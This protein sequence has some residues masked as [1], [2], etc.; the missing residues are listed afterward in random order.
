MKYILLFFLFPFSI[1][2]KER[3]VVLDFVHSSNVSREIAISSHNYFISQ[4]AKTDQYSI[5]EKSQLREILKEIEFQ[6]TGCT[7]TVC[8]IK[9][10]EMLS[11]NK[12][13]SG[14]II[15]KNNKHIITVT[16]RNVKD[17][18]LELSETI[19]L[20]DLNK[21]EIT[22]NT[23]VQRMLYPENKDNIEPEKNTESEEE[24][25]I[26]PIEKPD[27]RQGHYRLDFST[28]NKSNIQKNNQIKST[29][30][31]IT[32]L[33]KEDLDLIKK[34]QKIEDELRIKQQALN[35]SI[36]FPGWGHF[37]LNENKEGIILS[38]L[39]S[40]GMFTFLYNIIYKDKMTIREIKND[41][42]EERVLYFFINQNLNPSA[43]HPV[44][45]YHY[46]ERENS[47]LK[48]QKSQMW[49]LNLASITLALLST[50]A[51]MGDINFRFMQNGESFYYFSIRPE[52]SPS[53]Q[54]TNSYLAKGSQLE[55]TYRVRF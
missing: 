42:K 36:L 38:S 44:V 28:K 50:V 35:R 32:P 46:I 55:F 45:A 19:D 14:N 43:N 30:N 29:D 51:A 39:Y 23:F 52:I 7:D 13:V 17:K 48:S 15:K 25:T 33:T 8:E 21:I 54:N 41:A 5:I 4:V 22:M 53:L 9:I 20:Y 27:P 3:I 49:N 10:G 16:I 31:K 2:S 18:S 11:A 47:F 26:D 37:Y 24:K 40:I 12:I 6:Q 34:N 1:Y